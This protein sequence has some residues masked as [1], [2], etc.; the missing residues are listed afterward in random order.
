MM[1]RVC[2]A[3]LRGAAQ[4][5][6]TAVHLSTRIAD[7]TREGRLRSTPYPLE[8]VRVSAKPYGGVRH[9][10]INRQFARAG[11]LHVLASRHTRQ[12]RSRSQCS[13][14]SVGSPHKER[15]GD[16]WRE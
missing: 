15:S 12:H 6:D 8:V 7:H 3:L 11:G 16:T 10:W 4:R 14:F 9:I 13:D 1:L 2:S 5:A